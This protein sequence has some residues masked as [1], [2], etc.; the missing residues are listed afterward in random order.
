MNEY[1]NLVFSVKASEMMYLCNTPVQ[2]ERSKCLD[3]NRKRSQLEQYFVV[4]ICYVVEPLRLAMAT[5]HFQKVASPAQA[6]YP[7]CGRRRASCLPLSH[8]TILIV[9]FNLTLLYCF[10]DHGPKHL[11]PSA[12]V[13]S[14][15]LQRNSARL[16][17]LFRV[18]EPG[19]MR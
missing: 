15:C 7:T 18:N 10:I 8:I 3:V 9:S 2:Q 13:L 4:K 6:K 11:Q 14:S 19:E 16:G 12:V 5:M 1:A 17:S